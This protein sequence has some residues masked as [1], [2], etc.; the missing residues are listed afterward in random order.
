MSLTHASPPKVV[1]G[2]ANLNKFNSPGKMM[3]HLDSLVEAEQKN[4]KEHKF[5]FKLTQISS[6]SK[7]S[8]TSPIKKQ[9]SVDSSSALDTQLHHFDQFVYNQRSLLPERLAQQQTA[10]GKT[11]ILNEFF[12]MLMTE[13]HKIKSKKSKSPLKKSPVKG[14]KENDENSSPGKSPV[15]EERG[16]QR[17]RKND[18]ELG[19]IY[20]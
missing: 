8:Y 15:K 2:E 9:A 7:D 10:E 17:R 16:S 6:E 4:S 13:R 14:E 11:M 3:A 12:D 19:S 1:L 5:S 18:D 20:L